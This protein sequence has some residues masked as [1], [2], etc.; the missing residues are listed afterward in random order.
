[1]A[2]AESD[3]KF[4]EKW[5]AQITQPPAGRFLQNQRPESDSIAEFLEAFRELVPQTRFQTE[6]IPETELPG[7]ILGEGWRF[8]AVPEG[9]KLEMLGEI[10]LALDGQGTQLPQA[11]QSR[12]EKL[13]VAPDLNI[14]IAPQ[15]P[16][17][18]QMVRQLIPL[19]MTPPKATIALIDASLFTDFSRK[20]EIKAVPTLIVNG[21]YRLTGAFQLTE[22]LDLAEKTDP[23]QL[24]VAVWERMM[25][26]GQAGVMGELMLAK[27]E[28]FL[29]VL[30]LLSHPEI[31]IRL[32]AMVALE[33]VGEERPELVA[34]ILPNLWEEFAGSDMTVQGDIIYLIGEWGGGTWIHSLE[35]IKG[36][37]D[38]PELLEAVEEALEKIQAKDASSSQS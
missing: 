29:N 28:I 38:Q 4:V 5:Q 3:I 7:L 33:M 11:V 6:I 9:K 23:A 27:G 35:A 37:A 22:I 26:E 20:H 8:H 25:T 19:V 12:W 16:F 17:C 21:V 32:G 18:P 30:P 36:V 2:L 24:P 14:F 31:N 15:C 13:P 10:L 1:M 34:A